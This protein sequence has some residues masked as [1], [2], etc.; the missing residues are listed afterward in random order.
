M[1]TSAEGSA[2]SLGSRLLTFCWVESSPAC[3]LEWRYCRFSEDI[4][5]E[6]PP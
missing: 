6:C 2:L 3:L 1:F 5:R 4:G